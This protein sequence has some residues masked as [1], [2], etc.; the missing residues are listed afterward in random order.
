[1]D[2]IAIAYCKEGQSKWLNNLLQHV[3]FQQTIDKLPIIAKD[4]VLRKLDKSIDDYEAFVDIL[5]SYGN[6]RIFGKENERFYQTYDIK[7]L[8]NAIE[9]RPGLLDRVAIAYCNAGKPEWMDN[10]LRLLLSRARINQLPIIAKDFVLKELH[11]SV[12]DY[13]AFVLLLKDWKN[14]RIF[15]PENA[16]F[17]PNYNIRELMSEIK[18]NRKLFEFI[19]QTYFD[20]IGSKWME[21][22]LKYILP[23][24]E[25]N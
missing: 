25:S 8:R 20:R 1:L 22:V 18:Q 12:E 21:N 10:L 11:R 2:S 16:A 19:L 6:S 17:P 4:A 23:R 3:L 5:C 7:H 13:E 14:E 24:V 15:A 9:A